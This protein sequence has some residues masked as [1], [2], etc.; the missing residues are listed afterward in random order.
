ARKGLRAARSRADRW[1]VGRHGWSVL[2][3]GLRR[4]YAGGRRAFARAQSERSDESL[5]E[6][7]K[8]TKYFWYQLQLFESLGSRLIAALEPEVSRLANFLGDDHDLAVL[9]ERAVA[10]R[11]LFPTAASHRELLGLIARCRAGLQQ[12]AISLGRRVYAEQPAAFS[13]RLERYWRDWRRAG[14]AASGG[15]PTDSPR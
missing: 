10:A 11:E 2:G 4:T 8:Q 7:R 5:H 12:K 15:K 6:W 14:R 1:H 13:K 9:R 3:A